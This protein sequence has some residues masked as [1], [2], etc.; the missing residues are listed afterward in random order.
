MQVGT[1]AKHFP[2]LTL[3]VSLA[4][5]TFSPQGSK[6]LVVGSTGGVGQLVVSKLLEAGYK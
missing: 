1:L 3:V 6:V 4:S 5:L 2:R